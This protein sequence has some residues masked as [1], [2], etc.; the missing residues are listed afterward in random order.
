MNSAPTTTITTTFITA[1]ILNMARHF[2]IANMITLNVMQAVQY[3]ETKL[4]KQQQQ[5][6]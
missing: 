5:L 6:P 3:G 1:T 2:N 4:R